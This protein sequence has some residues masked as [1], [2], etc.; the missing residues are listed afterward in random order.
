M[1]IWRPI[2]PTATGFLSL[3][4]LKNLGRNPDALLDELRPGID[5]NRWYLNGGEVVRGTA[6]SWLV[7][8]GELTGFFA[9]GSLP[10]TGGGAITV[11]ANELWWVEDVDVKIGVVAPSVP[12]AL[13]QVVLYQ[14]S[15]AA[16]LPLCAG[17]PGF[18]LR[19]IVSN[20]QGYQGVTPVVLPITNG[21]TVPLAHVGRFFA[22]AGTEFG[23]MAGLISLVDSTP[24]LLDIGIEMTLRYTP[25][26]V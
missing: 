26:T 1:P 21:L 23:I 2:Q 24:A 15:A 11:P 12:T 14:A 6:D 7:A 3:L 19:H 4:G 25:V 18:A 8:S 13:D 20:P 10:I 16:R 9:V 5:M 17:P 22:P